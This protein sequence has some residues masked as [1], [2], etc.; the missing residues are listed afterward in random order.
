LLE[1]MPPLAALCPPATV[2]DKARYSAFAEPH[3][4]K[5]LRQREAAR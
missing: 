4:F 1:L 3:L 5:H 2:V